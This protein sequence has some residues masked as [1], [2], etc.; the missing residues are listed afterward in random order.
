[1]GGVNSQLLNVVQVTV[2]AFEDEWIDGGQMPAGFRVGGDA[3]TNLRFSHSGDREGVG[4]RDWRFEHAEFV[5]LNQADALAEAIDY[6]SGGG[7]AVKEEIAGVRYDNTD[8]GLYCPVIEREMADGDLTD[9]GNAI[10][11]TGWQAADVR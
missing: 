8:T 1:M 10:A 6:G 2:I 4:Q 3:L 5:D 9:I 7:D 11:R